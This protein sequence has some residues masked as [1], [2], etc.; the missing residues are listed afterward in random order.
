MNDDYTYLEYS[1]RYHHKFY[2]INILNS[3]VII[4]YGKIGY[5]GATKIKNLPSPEKAQKYYQ[6]QIA[7][8]TK[9]GY[10]YAIKGQRQPRLKH[11]HPNQLIIKFV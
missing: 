1:N 11:I 5:S 8:K 3:S 9:I 7:R 2:E 4:K 6:Q 10:Q